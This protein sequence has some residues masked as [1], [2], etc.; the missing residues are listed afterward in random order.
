[1]YLFED[2]LD[3][4]YITPDSLFLS[5]LENEIPEHIVAEYG[6][7]VQYYPAYSLFRAGV[8][9]RRFNRQTRTRNYKLD[10]TSQI[11]KYNQIK[12]GVDISEASTYTGQ[13]LYFR[14]DTYRPGVHPTNSRYWKFYQKQ[15]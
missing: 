5:Q 1:M 13:L 3:K 11:N 8:D 15:L 6:E 14:L 9:N 2:P 12:L 4:R 10:F 7:N